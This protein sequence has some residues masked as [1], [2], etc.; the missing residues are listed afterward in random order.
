M[1]GQDAARG[2]ISRLALDAWESLFRA[3]SVRYR[4]FQESD[5]WAG[6]SDRD[7]DVLYTLS[8][9]DAGMRQ[10]DL[11]DCL[12]ISQPSLSR[13]IERLVAEGLVD[14]RPDPA[15]RRGAI[16]SLTETG[17]QLQ[18]K[19][20]AGH[21]RDVTRALALRLTPEEM[22][23]LRDLARKRSAPLSEHTSPVEGSP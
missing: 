18:R 14:R 20:G 6:R 19:I 2:E 13:L 11:T 4:E 3:Q 12:L 21:A 10:K 9:D 22:S 8:R 5:A 23:T 17:R 15:D 7:F 1:V 16:L